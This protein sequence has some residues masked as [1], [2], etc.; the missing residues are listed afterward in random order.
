MC[1]MCISGATISFVHVTKNRLSCCW[2]YCER[3]YIFG[4]A[5]FSRTALYFRTGVWYSDPIP[6]QGQNLG[7]QNVRWTKKQDQTS[8]KIHWFEKIWVR[9]KSEIYILDFAFIT[10]PTKSKIKYRGKNIVSKKKWVRHTNCPRSRNVL[11]IVGGEPSFSHS[12]KHY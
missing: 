11:W 3:T 10:D 8:W 6:F 12:W 4:Q 9:Y 2:F 7:V 5:P 1:N